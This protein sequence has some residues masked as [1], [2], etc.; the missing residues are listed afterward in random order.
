MTIDV[1]SEA[2]IIQEA[3][4]PLLQKMSPTKVARFWAS[5]QVGQGD[6]LQW[7]DEAFADESVDSLYKQVEAFQQDP[8]SIAPR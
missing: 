7:R 4:E 2:E 1:V 3:S 6:Y 5:W 8:A